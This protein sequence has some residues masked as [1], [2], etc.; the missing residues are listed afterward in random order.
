MFCTP[1]ITRTARKPHRCT[2]CGE[3]INIGDKYETWRSVDDG[4]FTNK[5]HPECSADMSES[6]EY[7]YS[8]YCNDRPSAELIEQGATR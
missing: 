4:W 6:G 8:T 5:M 7:E 3:A 2:Y 1:S